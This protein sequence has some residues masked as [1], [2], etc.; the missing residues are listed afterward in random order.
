MENFEVVDI[1]LNKNITNSETTLEKQQLNKLSYS[2][3]RKLPKPTKVIPTLSELRISENDV[4]NSQISVFT[5]I[6][7]EYNKATKNKNLVY[8][9]VIP[10]RSINNQNK[11]NS[12]VADKKSLVK[13]QAN[14]CPCCVCSISKKS[15]ISACTFYSSHFY[16]NTSLDEMLVYLEFVYTYVKI[17]VLL[18][19]FDFFIIATKI[20]IKFNFC[21]THFFKF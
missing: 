13:S 18:N 2:N 20:A 10:H 4:L 1:T 6:P 14:D 11:K 5:D 17:I 9:E 21:R 3:E 16:T 8:P 12:I 19:Y 15:G 7:W